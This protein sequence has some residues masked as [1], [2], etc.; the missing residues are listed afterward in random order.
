MFQI[1]G[2]EDGLKMLERADPLILLLFLPIIPSALIA[3]KL[4]QWEDYV[5]SMLRKGSKY[6]ILRHILPGFA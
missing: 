5:L 2:E 1:F 4:V 3:M 6:P